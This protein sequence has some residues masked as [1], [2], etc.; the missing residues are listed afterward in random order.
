MCRAEASPHIGIAPVIAVAQPERIRSRP[1]A[2]RRAVVLRNAD[3]DVIVTLAAFQRRQRRGRTH[4]VIARA[5]ARNV[6]I[7]AAAIH[8]IVAVAAVDHV[9]A[10][11]AGHGVVA[12]QRVD[13]VIAL[14]AVQRLVE[15]RTGHIVVAGIAIDIARPAR[16]DDVVA[17]TAIKMIIAIP[18][19]DRVVAVLAIKII[20]ARTAEQHVLPQPAKQRIFVVVAVQRVVAGLPA[21]CVIVIAAAQNVLPVT[22]EQRVMTIATAQDIVTAQAIS[23]QAQIGALQRVSLRRAAIDREGIGEIGLRQRRRAVEIEIEVQF[24]ELAVVIHI[25]PHFDAVV[26]R[27]ALPRHIRETISHEFGRQLHARTAAARREHEIDRGRVER[28]RP[29]GRII[30]RVGWQVDQIAAHRAGALEIGDHVDRRRRRIRARLIEGEAEDVAA[31]AAGQRVAVEPADQRVVAGPTDQRVL[32]RTA[33]DRIVPGTAGYAILARTAADRH[34]IGRRRAIEPERIGLQLAGR[35]DHAHLGGGVDGQLHLPGT[36]Q[37]TLDV[38]DRRRPQRDIAGI[39]A[40]KHQRID[41]ILD[42]FAA[43][44]A[45]DLVR[46]GQIAVDKDHVVAGTAIDDIVAGAGMDF[47]VA[48]APGQ[49]VVAGIA[50]DHVIAEAAVDRVIAITA[51][52]QIVTLVAGQR[53]IIVAAGERVMTGAAIEHVIAAKPVEH[54]IAAQPLHHVSKSR[55]VLIIVRLISDVIDHDNASPLTRLESPRAACAD[56]RVLKSPARGRRP[57]LFRKQRQSWGEEK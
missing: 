20:V 17:G 38:D 31:G 7:A 54:I 57:N 49:I 42:Q 27:V 39:G 47:V 4:R 21:Q 32:P 44:A 53:V 8:N 56:S 33:A 30:G 2:R 13:D 51:I 18:A 41:V 43:A 15:R 29:V 50:I 12:A 36:D 46:C 37:E 24:R 55:A 35:I 14:A 9:I 23:D 40:R 48:N 5:A 3:I 19:R 45:I 10:V 1:A 22:A 28:D 52:E 16:R 25:D 6:D 11:A 34:V 26:R